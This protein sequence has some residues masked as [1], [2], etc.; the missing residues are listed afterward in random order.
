MG[1]FSNTVCAHKRRVLA[2]QPGGGGGACIPIP[3]AGAWEDPASAPRA[4]LLAQSRRKIPW[5]SR[6]WP[7]LADELSQETLEGAT[8]KQVQFTSA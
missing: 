5:L 6:A 3:K 2:G 4:L 7:L 1:W 8:W